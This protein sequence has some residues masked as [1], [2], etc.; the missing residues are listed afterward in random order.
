M[1]APAATSASRL[2]PRSTPIT[3]REVAG[4]PGGNARAGVFDDDGLCRRHA[5]ALGGVNER[6][7]IG[8]AREML[9][10]GDDAV[11]DGNEPFG[12]AGRAQHR[13]GVLRRRHDCARN[14]GA[15]EHVHHLQR[16]RVWLD[17]LPGE[18]S[19][20]RLVLAIPHCADRAVAG[21]I[22]RISPRQLDAAGGEE[23]L[24]ALVAR[25]A[26]D[27]GEVVVAVEAPLREQFRPGPLVDHCGGRDDPVEI[28]QH[29]CERRPVD[30]P[31]CSHQRIV[32]VTGR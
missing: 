16:S 7:R 1:S 24:H 28:E 25:Q 31:I 10:D 18:H 32:N 22:R 11:D 27:V 17:P 26:V 2:P 14:A 5:E 15:V 13:G 8:L 21:R 23:R 30:D 12:D 29:R 6:R 9:L 20:E 4:T 3:K 19:V